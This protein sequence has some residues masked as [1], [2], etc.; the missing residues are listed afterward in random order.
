LREL[1]VE[2]EADVFAVTTR[3]YRRDMG[4]AAAAAAAAVANDDGSVMRPPPQ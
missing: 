2:R 4:D 1:V 3:S